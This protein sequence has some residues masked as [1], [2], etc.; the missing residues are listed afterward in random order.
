MG[1]EKERKKNHKSNTTPK[2]MPPQIQI[3]G[4]PYKT[5]SVKQ[6]ETIQLTQNKKEM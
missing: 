4:D 1:Q 5:F 3:I 2:K 6:L